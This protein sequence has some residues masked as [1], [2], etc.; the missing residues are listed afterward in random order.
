MNLFIWGCQ[1]LWFL[2][3]LHRE[4]CLMNDNYMLFHCLKEW[5]AE[6][7]LFG[8]FFFPLFKISNGIQKCR[9]RQLNSG[10]NRFNVVISSIQS[11]GRIKRSFV[12]CYKPLPDLCM[13]DT[14]AALQGGSWGVED[15]CEHHAVALAGLQSSGTPCS[16]GAWVDP[17]QPLSSDGAQEPGP[18]A[19]LWVSLN[20]KSHH[21]RG[22]RSAPMLQLSSMEGMFPGRLGCPHLAATA[23]AN[24]T[25]EIG[26]S[27]MGAW[28]RASTYAGTR[29]AIAFAVFL[30]F[31]HHFSKT[32]SLPASVGF[33]LSQTDTVHSKKKGQLKKKT[34]MLF[35]LKS[36]S[37]PSARI[38]NK[39]NLQNSDF[40]KI[41]L[42]F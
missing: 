42:F 20:P 13:A 2:Y 27:W 30:L 3:I 41:I 33:W 26:C 19:W 4:I 11:P 34:N 7:T 17:A 40:K 6:K 9:P 38:Q 32:G 31:G 16:A 39:K 8:F 15:S 1:F 37:F 29:T 14:L 18:M 23:A 21:C 28:P 10:G 36:S 24:L 12:L 22:W 25:P 5:K 35:F